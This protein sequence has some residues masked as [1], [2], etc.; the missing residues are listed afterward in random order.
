MTM[1]RIDQ[2]KRFPISR[3]VRFFG[4]SIGGPPHG[5]VATYDISEL[6]IDIDRLGFLLGGGRESKYMDTDSG[7]VLF[8]TVDH[9]GP[10]VCFRLCRVDRDNLPQ[11]E[12]GGSIEELLL[13]EETG[14]M[15]TTYG[16]VLEPGLIG[17]VSSK[18]GPS[19]SGIAKY[20]KDK[21]RNIPGKITVGP[22]VHKDIIDKLND[23]ETISLFHFKLHPSQ[24][25]IVRGRWDELDENFDSQ[26][27]IWSEQSSL[28]TIIAPT[29]DSSRRAYPSLIRSIVS[30]AEVAGLLRKRDSKFLVKGQRAGTV[31]DVV[32]NILSETLS[33]EQEIVKSAVRSSA[34]DV[35][36]AYDAIRRGYNDLKSDIENAM[37]TGM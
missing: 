37:E 14:L 29:R 6:L 18:G 15:E 24:I 13:D 32:L 23:F 31:S 30:L 2:D 27:R 20:L 19:M 10:E 1:P 7:R 8:T 34:L 5:S 12:K 17:I 3:R 25:P 16:I 22:L 28:E 9:P 26:L 35:E 33:V 21:G 36:S 4:V 11:T